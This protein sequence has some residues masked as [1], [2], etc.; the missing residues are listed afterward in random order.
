MKTIKTNENK[1]IAY[2]NDIDQSYVEL[3]KVCDYKK[4]P[5]SVSRKSLMTCSTKHSSEKY[6]FVCEL[7]RVV[8]KDIMK[9][10]QH[11]HTTYLINDT[12][13]K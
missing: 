12:E 7:E 11:K 9:A 8:A 1:P 3:V 5:T 6:Y 2:Y 13:I 10:Y 4:V